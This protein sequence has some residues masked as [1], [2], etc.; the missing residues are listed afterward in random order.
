MTPTITVPSKDYVDLLEQALDLRS[1]ALPNASLDAIHVRA[2]RVLVAELQKKYGAI[3]QP[4]EPESAQSQGAQG[5]QVH[6]GDAGGTS[7]QRFA[8]RW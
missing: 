6:A 8:G 2:L 3:A 7:R 1:H 4:R 5:M